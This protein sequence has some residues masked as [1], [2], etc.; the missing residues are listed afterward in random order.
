[1]FFGE[2]GD[3]N[4]GMPRALEEANEKPGTKAM[5]VAAQIV[6]SEKK[7]SGAMTTLGTNGDGWTY[8]SFDCGNPRD[9][10]VATKQ[11]LNPKTRRGF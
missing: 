2:S 3:E 6:P 5:F 8:R 9:S 1:L 7:R 10:F 11:P 4:I